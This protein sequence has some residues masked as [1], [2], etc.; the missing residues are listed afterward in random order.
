MNTFLP[1]DYKKPAM[2][3]GYMKLE[4]GD[5]VFRVLSDAITGFEYWTTDNKP[6]RSATMPKETPNIKL[7]KNDIPTKIKHFWA[8]TVWN[9]KT[10]SVEILEITQGSIQDAIIN[11]SSD[12][13]WGDPKG[14]DIK[15]NRKGQGLDTEYAISPKPRKELAEEIKEAKEKKFVNLKALYWGGNPFDENEKT[16]TKNV[17]GVEYPLD[18]ITLEDV[19]F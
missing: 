13:D 4:D 10:G 9:Y 14:Y 12:E 1:K 7:D 3:G 17:N 5:N 18:D 11:L 16:P 2:G 15:I 19:G 8:F 6:V